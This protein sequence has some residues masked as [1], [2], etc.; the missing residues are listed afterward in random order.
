VCCVN[1]SQV[2]IGGYRT[3]PFFGTRVI[4]RGIGFS[5]QGP[6]GVDS[7]SGSVILVTL[8]GVSTTNFLFVEA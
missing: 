4:S 3:E 7:Q 5:F 8:L 2:L 1:S 6:R